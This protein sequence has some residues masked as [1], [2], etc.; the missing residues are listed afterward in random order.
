MIFII[1]TWWSLPLSCYK[2]FTKRMYWCS[3]CISLFLLEN[4]IFVYV[5]Q[6]KWTKWKRHMGRHCWEGWGMWCRYSILNGCVEWYILEW[7]GQGFGSILY[8]SSFIQRWMSAA[9]FIQHSICRVTV[10]AK[11]ENYV[12]MAYFKYYPQQFILVTV[13]YH[14]ICFL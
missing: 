13:R 1:Y 10:N 7:Y 5:D 3:C 14:F 11:I 2:K 6:V 8:G 4:G 12:V 9:W